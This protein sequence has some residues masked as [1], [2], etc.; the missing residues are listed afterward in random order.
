LS[1]ESGDFIEGFRPQQ[2][3]AKQLVFER[4][5]GIFKQVCDDAR[6]SLGQ[7]FVLLVDEI[8]RGDIPRIFGELLPLLEKDKRGNQAPCQFAPP[9]ISAWKQKA[10]EAGRVLATTFC[11]APHKSRS[12]LLNF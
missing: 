6:R 9:A 11:Q 8:N 3:A 7:K 5:P 10:L 12:G 1:R 4:C 2:N